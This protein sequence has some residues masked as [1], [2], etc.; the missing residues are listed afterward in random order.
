MFASSQACVVPG[1]WP[2]GITAGARSRWGSGCVFP[3]HSKYERLFLNL[4]CFSFS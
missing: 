4:R 2:G 3:S 1:G